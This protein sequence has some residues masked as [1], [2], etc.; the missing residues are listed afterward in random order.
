MAKFWKFWSFL[1]LI[2]SDRFGEE[3]KDGTGKNP[4][5]NQPIFRR[6]HSVRHFYGRSI[7]ADIIGE[8]WTAGTGW[9]G[10]SRAEPVA[11]AWPVHQKYGKT[12]QNSSIFRG[13]GVGVGGGS[14]FFFI[15]FSALDPNI[16]ADLA[17]L[18]K[19]MSGVEKMKEQRQHLLADFKRKLDGDDITKRILIPKDEQLDSFL[20]EELK[21]HDEVMGYLKQK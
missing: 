20:G 13:R 21:K 12:P 18:N 3:S 5:R 6:I 14:R 15:I 19:V 9:F 8:E 2:F 7:P 4:Q 1:V 10:R 11:V 17:E 16:S